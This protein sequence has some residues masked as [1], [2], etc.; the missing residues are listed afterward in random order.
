MNMTPTE[1]N[2][3]KTPEGY[4]DGFSAQV[5]DRIQEKTPQPKLRWVFRVAYVASIVALVWFGSNWFATDSTDEAL[6]ESSI[7]LYLADNADLD[8]IETEY[9]Y[10][11]DAESTSEIED[12][13]ME[14]D[15][16]L[17]TIIYEY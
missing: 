14:D 3:F 7:E 8:D 9:A 5:V 1:N 6:D 16:D 11:L 13:L 12:Y 2:S 4:F 10:L 15:I 17:S